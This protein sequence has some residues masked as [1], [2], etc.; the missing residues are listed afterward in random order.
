ML[1]RPLSPLDVGSAL[2]MTARRPYAHCF[3][4]SALERRALAD[5]VGVFDTGELR[6]VA[7]IAGN[8]VTTDLDVASA[9]ALADLL[10]DV[11]RRAASIVGRSS[12]GEL[13]WD[14]LAGRWGRPRAV[15]QAQ[16]LMVLQTA[17]AIAADPQVR[18]SLPDELD[19][20]LPACIEMFTH[21][22]GVSPVAHGMH[23]AYRRRIEDNIATGRSFIRRDGAQL[24]FKAEIGAI[25]SSACQVQG[26]WV[27]P[28]LRGHGLAAPAMAAVANEAMR[29]IAPAVELYVN[30]FNSA[31]L[32]TYERVGFEQVDTF[33]TVFF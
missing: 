30:D 31:A 4:A 21:E 6:V 5:L 1:V 12:D 13:L 28:D 11:G 8:C 14:A 17:P 20:V 24:A 18:R 27:R 32:R 23:N 25:S 2:D 10:A 22:V 19:I 33:R 26:V 16:P 29:S 7:S 15:R 9:Y 3:L